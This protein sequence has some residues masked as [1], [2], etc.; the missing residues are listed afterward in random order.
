MSSILCVESLCWQGGLPL[1]VVV[2]VGIESDPLFNL[3]GRIRGPNV[4]PGAL[5]SIVTRH[6]RTFTVDLEEFQF[7]SKDLPCVLSTILYG[8]SYA[9]AACPLVFSF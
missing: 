1:S 9:L 8:S 2:N 7:M 5:R 3:V 4:S 6:L